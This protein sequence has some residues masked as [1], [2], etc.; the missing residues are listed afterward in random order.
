VPFEV[1]RRGAASAADPAE[2]FFP[3]LIRLRLRESAGLATHSRKRC[4]TSEGA[5]L[6][7]A[8]SLA[9]ICLVFGRSCV[10]FGLPR[11]LKSV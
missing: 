9:G 5:I 7:M 6:R 1:R 11:I 3:L 8:A 2:F 10:F 4:G